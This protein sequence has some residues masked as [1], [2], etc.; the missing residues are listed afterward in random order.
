MT[1]LNTTF[2]ELMALHNDLVKD[3]YKATDVKAFESYI[4]NNVSND[5]G[6]EDIDAY[7]EISSSETRSGNPVIFEF[8]FETVDT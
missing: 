1:L 6:T 7:I 5:I 8:E 2:E 4:I 3:A